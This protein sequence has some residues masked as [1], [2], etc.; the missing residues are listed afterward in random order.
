MTTP[1]TV[2]MMSE[3]AMLWRCLHG[4]SLTIDSIDRCDQDGNIQWSKFRAR[5]LLLLKNLMDTYGACA[6][7][8]RSEDH[9]VGQLRF[10]PRAV[11]ELAKPGLG[12][13]LQQKFPNG[14]ANEF[15]RMRFP[16]PEEIEDKTLVIHCMMLTSGGQEGESYR[17][18]GIGTRMAR[19]LINWATMNGWHAI[20]ATAYEDLPIVYAITGQTGRSFWE[21]LGFRHVRTE[22]EP[23]LE[24]ESD[25]VRKMREEAKARGMDPAK[26]KNK[27]IMILNLR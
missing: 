25:F 18:K 19:T 22:P 27:Y 24:E 16:S 26:I 2:E 7:I 20:E 1:I 21:K 10:Y 6:V 4:G 23:A 13:C 12:M 5:N 15:G 8:A 9:F 17:R 3:N 14:P 11:F